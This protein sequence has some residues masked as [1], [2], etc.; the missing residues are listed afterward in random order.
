MGANRN[1]LGFRDIP[2]VVEATETAPG[3]FAGIEPG[4]VIWVSVKGKEGKQ[5]QPYLPKR[6]IRAYP[7]RRAVEG[8]PESK[9]I[10]GRLHWRDLTPGEADVILQCK[11]ENLADPVN[12]AQKRAQAEYKRKRRMKLEGLLRGIGVRCP[13]EDIYKWR[14]SL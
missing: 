2:K 5:D 8:D 11:R 3:E 4:N 1:S 14:M 9:D 12:R 6:V 13:L 10:P 7:G